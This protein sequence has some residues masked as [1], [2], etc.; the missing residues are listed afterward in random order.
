MGVLASRSWSP[1]SMTEHELCICTCVVAVFHALCC[2]DMCCTVHLTWASSH[3]C[4]WQ[5]PQASW[6]RVRA[7]VRPTTSAVTDLGASGVRVGTAGWGTAKA[8][9]YRA[10]ARAYRQKLAKDDA[11]SR[12]LSSGVR[13]EVG[14]AH[15]ESIYPPALLPQ[16]L[17]ACT[18]R[19]TPVRTDTHD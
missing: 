10:H 11:T 14:G 17:L 9:F 1:P 15:H 8:S 6:D 2:P 13:S 18:P 3:L 5:L 19:R 16:I 7:G 4:D 12:T